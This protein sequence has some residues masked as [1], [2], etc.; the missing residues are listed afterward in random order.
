MK[1]LTILFAALTLSVGLWAANSVITFTSTKKLYSGDIY[2]LIYDYETGD[3]AKWEAFKAQYPE[4]AYMDDPSELKKMGFGFFNPNCFLDANGQVLNYTYNYDES[5]HA[6]TITFAGELVTMYGDE[7]T[8]WAFYECTALTSITLPEGLTSIGRN[9]FVSCSLASV[10]L[11]EGLTTI[12]D[13]AFQKCESLTSITIPANVTEIG[14]GAFINCSGLT[15]FYVAWTTTLPT[16]GSYLFLD[17][18]IGT[19]TLHVP[20]GSLALYQNADQWKCFGTFVEYNPLP[21]IKTAAIAEINAAI[22]GVTDEAILAIATTAITNINNATTEAGVNS[23]KTQALADI[24]LAK[25]KADAIAEI[26]TAGQGIQNTE[27]NNWI[28]GAIVDIKAAGTDTK[29]K[30]DNIKNQILSMIQLFQDG[31]A[32]GIE[33]GKAAGLAEAAAALPTDPEGTTGHTVTIT[34]GDKTLKLVN[35]DKVTYGKQE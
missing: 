12:G 35:P 20:A 14:Y 25:Y 26:Q 33:E 13:Q 9:S 11:P 28:N 4:F 24:D 8:G 27:M 2:E 32:E 10:T 30:V 7:G 21:N 3:G 17:A 34:K 22:D 19:A 23:I 29:E 31:K 16:I 5:T 18:S 15:D 6:G 1:K